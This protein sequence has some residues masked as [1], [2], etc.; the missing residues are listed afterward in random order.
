MIR[1]TKN[2][3]GPFVLGAILVGA[4]CAHNAA[5]PAPVTTDT[6]TAKPAKPQL[7]S[8]ATPQANQDAETA[9]G[10]HD[11]EAA[12]AAL[13]NVNLF[14]G[15]NDAILTEEARTK[16]SAVADV[17][18]KHSN[19]RLQIQ[20]N[21]DERGTEAYNLVLGQQRADS[22][23]KYLVDLGVLSGQVTTVSYGAEKPKALGHDEDAWK[24]NRR[25]DVIVTPPA[26]E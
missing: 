2:V 22:A 25:D 16:L 23:R 18:V 11:L 12:V 1:A 24:V 6:E 4:G 19:L 14:F 21:C 8:T 9:K 10:Q 3:V 26:R 15:F 13:Q 20:G 7:V 17:L 5:A